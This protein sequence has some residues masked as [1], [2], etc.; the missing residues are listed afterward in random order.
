MT[1]NDHAL[2]FT[3]IFKA[4]GLIPADVSQRVSYLSLLTICFLNQIENNK[5]IGF[6]TEILNNDNFNVTNLDEFGFT[7]AEQSV[8]RQ[9]LKLTT[10]G[11]LGET[12]NNIVSQMKSVAPE[13]L[14]RTQF[15][16]IYEQTLK[17]LQEPSSKNREAKNFNYELRP[18]DFSRFIA[19]IS[20]DGKVSAYDALASTG[21][22]SNYLAAIKPHWQYTTESFVQDPEYFIHKFV[23]AGCDDAFIHR[24]YALSQS[25]VINE[26]GFDLAYSLCE[27]RAISKSDSKN[28]HSLS[29]KGY[30]DPK[31]I[32]EKTIPSKY[33]EHAL[34]QHL[35][36]SIKT[37]GMAIAFI[38]K[39]PLQRQEE[40]EARQ[41]L[42]ENNYVDAVVQLPSS[43]LNA[44]TVDLYA[45]I[46]KKNRTRGDVLFVNASE[47]YERSTKRNR[48]INE[49]EIAAILDNRQEVIGLSKSVSVERIIFEGYLL[50]VTRYVQP[51]KPDSIGESIDELSQALVN[52]QKLTS[53]LFK[54][55][56]NL[57]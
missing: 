54:K 46:L 28:K 18:D 27:P 25:T 15:I 51:I 39:G 16:T 8:A 3:S 29:L 38:S 40:K 7:E 34:I 13:R 56:S 47:F 12:L 33:I 14:S 2:D 36:W 5:Y 31:R 4:S 6:I 45:L 21:E 42:L 26:S 24:S 41:F 20:S 48:L 9:A 44:K 19:A 1:N 17:R 10:T 32:N 43:L 37:D 23:L 30:F 35:V 57:N 50:N 53:E 11:K 49:Q 55:L 22:I 52:Q